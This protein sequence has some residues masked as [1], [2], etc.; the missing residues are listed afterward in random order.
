MGLLCPERSGG[1]LT[2]RYKLSP[3][4]AHPGILK[5]LKLPA[6]VIFLFASVIQAS[7]SLGQ[8]AHCPVPLP[9]QVVAECPMEEAK[10]KVTVRGRGW[11]THSLQCTS[12]VPAMPP[13]AQECLRVCLAVKPPRPTPLRD[14]GDT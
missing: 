3:A 2:P 12:Q 10:G 5:L 8:L 9:P 4:G 11:R 14:R 1:H 7:Q 13:N 6:D